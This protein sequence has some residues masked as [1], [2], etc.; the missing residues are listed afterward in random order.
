MSKTARTFRTSTNKQVRNGRGERQGVVF[1]EM[2]GRISDEAR[3][4]DSAFFPAQSSSS[5]KAWINKSHFCLR[6]I[7]SFSRDLD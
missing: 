5:S 4:A 1:S 7:T 3:H 6:L 2:L